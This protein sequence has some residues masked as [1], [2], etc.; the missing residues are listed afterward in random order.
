VLLPVGPA[1]TLGLIVE[2]LVGQALNDAYLSGR[3][4]RIAVFFGETSR[5]FE[6][7]L[8]DSGGGMRPNGRPR[9]KVLLIARL[10]VLQLDGTLDMEAGAE[11]R[12]VKAL[13]AALTALALLP[14]NAGEASCA[15][16][17]LRERSPRPAQDEGERG[18]RTNTWLGWRIWAPATWAGSEARTHRSAR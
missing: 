5:A 11:G 14:G 17:A 18:W 1:I 2:Q 9:A 10:L 8:G 3:A 15:A 13:M 12:P 4:G 16:P 7:T 6:L